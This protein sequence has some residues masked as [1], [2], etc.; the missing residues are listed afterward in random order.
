MAQLNQECFQLLKY[1]KKIEEVRV[2]IFSY[3]TKDLF[4]KKL[5]LHKDNEEFFFYMEEIEK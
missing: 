3:Q 4:E 1:F 2:L 5:Y